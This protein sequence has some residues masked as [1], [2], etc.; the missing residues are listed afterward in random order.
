MTGRSC[1]SGGL[2]RLGEMDRKEWDG[3][4]LGFESESESER[5]G[6]FC[7]G[8]IGYDAPL[9]LCNTMEQRVEES[10]MVDNDSGHERQDMERRIHPSCRRR[11]HHLRGPS[12]PSASP[13]SSSTHNTMSY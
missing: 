7:G 5:E 4:D 11:V 10:V 13:I 6:W 9:G 3:L 8:I 2:A 12:A 1:L